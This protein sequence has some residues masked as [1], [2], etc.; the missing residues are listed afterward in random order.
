MKPEFLEDLPPKKLCKFIL[1]L[2]YNIAQKTKEIPV[3]AVVCSLSYN[4]PNG[5]FFK[6]QHYWKVESIS[7]NLVKKYN[8]PIY[9]AEFLAFQKLK[10]KSKELYLSDKILITNLEP[11]LLCT[12]LSISYRVEKIFYFLKR[13]KGFSARDIVNLSHKRKQSS[14]KKIL[15]HH[16]KI[17]YL[18]EYSKIQR[19]I[20]KNF[21]R[22]LRN[23][24]KS[25]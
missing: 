25:D 22:K 12:S 7:T 9:H 24:S 16:P 20:I 19:S 14:K 17:V 10:R 3:V 6:N 21:F 15:N 8:N 1:K 2:S 11:C 5:L 13:N 18:K 23:F 4:K